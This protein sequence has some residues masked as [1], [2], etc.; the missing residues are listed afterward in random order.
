MDKELEDLCKQLSIY[1]RL[2]TQFKQ[3]ENYKKIL[4]IQHRQEEFIL[5]CILSSD[6]SRRVILQT[7]NQ[8][9]VSDG[10]SSMVRFK[11]SLTA[12]RSTVH[13]STSNVFKSE[14]WSK[15]YCDSLV[16]RGWYIKHNM[17][18]YMKA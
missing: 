4:G 12:P 11:F 3:F 18:Y 17:D 10:S 2:K 5:L 1:P 7:I 8:I 16:A 13:Y 14:G 6:W 9:K 15:P